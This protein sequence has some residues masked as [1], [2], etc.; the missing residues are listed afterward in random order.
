MNVFVTIGMLIFS[1]LLMEYKEP[2][3]LVK[4]IVNTQS[5]RKEFRILINFRF[6]TTEIRGKVLDAWLEIPG[7][8]P[9]E[10]LSM[11]MIE[12][13]PITT[14]W[15]TNTVSWDYPWEIPGGDFDTSSIRLVPAPAFTGRVDLSWY[16]IDIYS[17]LP[18]YGILLK[19][20]VVDGNSFT[21]DPDDLVQVLRQSTL[22]IKFLPTKRR[23]MDEK[24]PPINPNPRRY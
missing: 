14:P 16:Y 19:P 17:G 9:Q 2:A 4:V 8:V 21:I 12:L 13:A 1:Q 18:R 23:R 7:D 22:H 11:T 24:H 20:S 5:Q 3:P 6:D 15:D 10:L